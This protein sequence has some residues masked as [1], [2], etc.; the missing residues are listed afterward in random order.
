MR[1]IHVFTT[2]VRTTLFWSVKDSPPCSYGG[3]NERE[4]D[5]IY[6]NCHFVNTFLGQFY[7]EW[8]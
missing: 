5:N 8:R 3:G 1:V 7:A 4:M 2:V 6:I